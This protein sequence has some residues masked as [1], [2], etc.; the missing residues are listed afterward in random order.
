MLGSQRL[1]GESARAFGAYCL[2][3]DLGP[4]RSLQQAWRQHCRAERSGGQ[5][6]GR[7]RRSG[8]EP[9][10]CPGAWTAFSSR[11]HWVQRATAYDE[12]RDTELQAI[13]E[14]LIRRRAA[15]QYR[16]ALPESEAY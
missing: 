15:R 13:Y 10:A 9:T 6:G 1:P 14:G 11:Y 3:R 8:E 7:P 4:Q 16:A 12:A 2:Y 5:L